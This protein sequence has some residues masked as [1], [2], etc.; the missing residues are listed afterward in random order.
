MSLDVEDDQ[1]VW[2][3]QLEPNQIL[4]QMLLGIQWTSPPA[5]QQYISM[6]VDSKKD[7]NSTWTSKSGSARWRL[8]RWDHW[9]LGRDDTQSVSQVCQTAWSSL[10]SCR[11]SWGDTCLQVS[12]KTQWR[13]NCADPIPP[14]PWS[15]FHWCGRRQ[16]LHPQRYSDEL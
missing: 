9:G 16:E 15:C 4:S 13:L 3:F 1:G 14:V 10:V 6:D 12:F 7:V 11:F 2:F 5:I 8:V